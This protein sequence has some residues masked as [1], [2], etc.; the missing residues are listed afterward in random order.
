MSH[1]FVCILGWLVYCVSILASV[2]PSFFNV[3]LNVIV[4]A[5]K[6]A[7]QVIFQYM[8]RHVPLKFDDLLASVSS[9]NDQENKTSDVEMVG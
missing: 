6:F 9:S 7:L 8:V 4:H 1:I 3:Y 5:L 2:C